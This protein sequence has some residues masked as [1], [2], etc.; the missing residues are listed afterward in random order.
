MTLN[1]Q[2]IILITS[3]VGLFIVLYFGCDTKPPEVKNSEKSLVNT[4]EAT[5][6]QNI[7]KDAGGKLD[8]EQHIVIDY[9]T[10]SLGSEE[11]SSRIERLEALSS[12]W[13]E[14]GFPSIAGYYAEEIAN[15]RNTEDAWSICG[16]TYTLCIKLSEQQDVKDF[17]AGRA[18]KAFE[19]AISLNPSNIDHRINMALVNVE[20]PPNGQPMTGIL[21]LR[22]LNEKY[23]ENVAVLNQ[24]ARLAIRTN[25]IDKAL[26]RLEQAI[27]IEPENKNTNCL[28]A[29]AYG[30]AGQAPRE[31]SYR[32]K[33]L[34]LSR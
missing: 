34:T 22:E 27:A 13:Y 15:K 21:Q 25:Q 17:C 7:M 29:E 30:L 4:I 6:I 19:S 20:N 31:E 32:E 12:K 18:L 16:T 10:K 28:L 1:R 5:S 3:C 33:C 11:D 2:Q 26:E 9:M 8:Q 24:L 14:F 23:P